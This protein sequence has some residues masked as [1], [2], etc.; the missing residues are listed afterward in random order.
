MMTESSQPEDAFTGALLHMPVPMAKEALDLVHDDD[1]ADLLNVTIVKV[2]RALVA[3]G[4]APDPMAVS[5]RARADGIVAGPE[6]IRMLTMRV[7]NLYADVI[8]PASWR[9]Y[10]QGVIDDALRRAFIAMGT[11]V[12]QAAERSAFEV[13]VDLLDAECRSVRRL[14]DRRQVATASAHARL[15]SV[16]G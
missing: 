7:A 2:A 11:R 6:A 10:A 14:L 5:I 1:F 16:A 8:T 13:M 12:L 4:V 15:R 9:Y 3:D